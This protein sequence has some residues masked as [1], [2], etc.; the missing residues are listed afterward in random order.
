M[1]EYI[2]D[3]R[4]AIYQR[5][6]FAYAAIKYMAEEEGISMAEWSAQHPTLTEAEKRV[7]DQ[8]ASLVDKW[9]REKPH[10]WQV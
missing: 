2:T 8:Q 4:Q 6:P 9:M 1:I 7:Y 3:Y 5:D 10:E